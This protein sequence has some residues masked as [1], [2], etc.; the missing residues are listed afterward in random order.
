MTRPALLNN[1]D[2]AGLRVRLGYAAAYGDAVNEALLLPT[3]YEAAQR[4]YPIL[5]RRR[6]DGAL[7]AVALLGLDRDENLFLDGGEWRAGYVPAIHQRGPFSITLVARDSGD[8]APMIQVDLDHPRLTT[9]GDGTE[10]FLPHGGQS[11]FLD[12]IVRT[13]RRAHEGLAMEAAMFAAFEQAGL[14]RPVTLQI[15]I[16]E[17]QRYDLPDCFAIDEER[18][19][20]LDAGALEALHH[21]GFLRLAFMAAAS[22][23]NVPRLIE[24]KNARRRARQAEVA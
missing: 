8:P 6:E 23:G 4:D 20:A 12:H 9:D 3:E 7:Y 10:I 17:H 13:L 5:F 14:V 16:D 1:I 15:A 11:P 24:M 19:A 18:L 21:A 2:H 22:L